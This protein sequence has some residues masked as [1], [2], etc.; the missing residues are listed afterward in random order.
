VAF[1]RDAWVIGANYWPEPDIAIKV[2]YVMVRNQS[3]VVRAPNALN[4]GLG[5]WF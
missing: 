1:D 4:V 2:D 3:S 5:W